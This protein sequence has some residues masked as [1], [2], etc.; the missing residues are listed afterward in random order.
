VSRKNSPVGDSGQS[1]PAPKS[2]AP[3]TAKEI[4]AAFGTSSQY[5]P[6][7]S[8]AQAAELEHLKPSTMTRKV[9]EGHYKGCVKRGKPLLFWRDRLIQRSWSKI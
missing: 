1:A 5:G 4:T 6:I 2:S 8:L 3:L 7:L 9:S